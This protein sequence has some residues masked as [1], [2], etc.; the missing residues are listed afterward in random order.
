MMDSVT[1]LP[2]SMASGYTG[3][4]V[5]VE[6]LKNLAIYLLCWKYIDSPELARLFFEHIICK[7]GVPDNLVTD[8]G[9]QLTSRFLTRVCSH[10]STD[11]W[12]STAFRPQTERQTERH[13]LTME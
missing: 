4:L 1:D 6:R 9:T 2:E 7:W 3:I 13:N 11:D 8:R 5:I 10:F 12:H